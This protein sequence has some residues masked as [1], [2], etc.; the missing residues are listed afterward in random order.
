MIKT[1]FACHQHSLFGLLRAATRVIL[2]VF[3]INGTQIWAKGSNFEDRLVV[4]IESVKSS[5][6]AIGTYNLKQTPKQNYYGTGFIVGDGKLIITCAHTILTLEEEKRTKQLRIFH[7]ALQPQGLKVIPVATDEQHDLI[8][9]RL[10]AGEFPPLKLGDSSKVREGHAVAFTGYPVGL[11]FGLNPATNSGI[12][13]TITPIV[14]PS[15]TARAIKK[16]IIATLRQPYDVLQIDA[17]AYP[18]NSGSPVFRISTG[19]VVGIL[20]KVFVK[21]KKEHLLK[22][23]SGISYAIPSNFA[24]SLIAAHRRGQK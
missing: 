24:R 21:S 14:L 23:P 11:V 18:G 3:F 5:V 6:V 19:E 12:I 2:F 17:T 8:L 22:D 20:N 9:L 10:E 16:E 4:L 7:R 15:P 13:S 1:S